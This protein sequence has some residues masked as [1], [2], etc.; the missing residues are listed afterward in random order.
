MNNQHIARLEAQLEQF[1]EGAFAHLFGKKIRAQ[2]IALQLARAMEDNAEASPRPL[3]PDYYII[4]VNPDARARLL[5]RNAALEQ[6]LGQHLLEL[7]TNS[8]YRLNN[9]P[10]VEIQAD[11]TLAAGQVNVTA[12]HQNYKHETTDI[13]KRV[14][15]PPPQ[16]APQNP[17]LLI[18]GRAAMS[19]NLS[20]I[21]IGR[22]R[23]NH[24][25]IDDPTVSRYHLQLRLRFGRYML[26][27]TQSQGGTFVNNA[28]VKEHILQTGDVIRIGNTQLVYMEDH[29]PSA[30]QTGVGLPPIPSLPEN[31]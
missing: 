3:A 19:L 24:I 30:T 18:Q 9:P 14:D 2:D 6:L 7:A 29:A 28:A 5:G 25:V 13:L 20:I 27:D 1:V 31:E 26:F 11:A 16:T 23:D 4:T 10:I 17:Q 12:H 8:G 21:N 15:M 22:S